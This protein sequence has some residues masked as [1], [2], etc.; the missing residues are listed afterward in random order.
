MR[1]K[2]LV[3]FFCLLAP[4]AFGQGDRGTITGTVADP[5][6]A[7]VAGAAIEA[8]H[9]ET[10]AAYPTVSTATGN[11]TLSQ[12]P[13]GT[14][15]IS[16]NVPGFKKYL[17][18]GLTVQ[19][20]ETLRIDVT[21]EVGS[22]TE[23]V[24]VQA[25]AP[26]LK[27]ES[28]ELSHNVT[29]ERMNDL[30]VLAVGAAAG[31]SSIRNPTAVAQLVPGTFL[32]ANVNLKVNGAPA[33]T[34]SFRIEGQ[35]ASNGY[36]AAVP[37]Q[38]Q[39]SVD[40]IQ[41]VTI[42]TSNFAAEYGQVGGGFFNYT[43][44]S[45]TNQ[46]HGSV[47]DYFVNEV[48]N[49]NTPWVNAKP[50]ARRNDYGF[51]VGGPVYIPKIYNGHD[52]TFF[53]FNWEQYRETEI[54]NN[55]LDTVPT[56]LYRAGNFTQALTGRTLG[57]DPLGRPIPE[58]GIY[59]PN[60]QRAAPSGQIIRDQFPN[61]TIPAARFDPVALK[62][63][64]LIPAANQGNG[65]INNAVFPFP[66]T[67]ITSIPAFKIDHSVGSKMKFSYYWSETK[68]DS[69]YSPT[70]GGADGL[71]EPISGEIGTFITGRVQRGNLDYTATPTVL[72][73][74]G[75][76]YQTDYFTDDPVVTNFNPQQALGLTGVPVNR[77]FPYITGL[78]PAGTSNGTVTSTCGGQGGMKVMGPTTNRH[79][80]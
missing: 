4:A 28:G 11:Y 53:F 34:S 68:T 41:E 21:L 24:T 20:A 29:G 35:D 46:L 60:T 43:M 14:Y 3:V 62:I 1:C 32:N 33:N 26:L 67:R 8:R 77:L 71:P 30:P 70:L 37:A 72:L 22:A 38:V 65:V 7:L 42:Q 17:R 6:G 39:P 44:K 54:I 56:D 31:S 48:F 59:D 61:N 51:T 45:G 66:S 74:F 55:I 49:A 5:A 63:Q 40:S 47:Y 52:R 69:Q 50:T 79:P 13:A 18:Q 73:H 58:G 19:V 25:D 75:A 27:T 76:G 80:L 78:C 36:V 16:V 12:L 23:S 15:E 64:A 9:V 10:G 57:T 2:S